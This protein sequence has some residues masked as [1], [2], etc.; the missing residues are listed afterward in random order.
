ME[1]NSG[2]SQYYF[3]TIGSQDELE[4]EP[5][6]LTKQSSSSKLRY[7]KNNSNLFYKS[8]ANN[9][10]NGNSAHYYE[11]ENIR[12][13]EPET[14]EQPEYHYAEEE[15]QEFI[16][17]L[18]SSEDSDKENDYDEY[19]SEKVKTS[20]TSSSKT[21]EDE[22]EVKR[23]ERSSSNRRSI[24]SMNAYSLS[25]TNSL[26]KRRS[27]IDNMNRVESSE[28]DEDESAKI[29]VIK[30]YEKSVDFVRNASSLKVMNLHGTKNS[31]PD[32]ENTED[33]EEDDDEADDVLLNPHYIKD[34]LCLN[35]NRRESQSG[36]IHLNSDLTLKSNNSTSP[37]YFTNR[38]MPNIVIN[39]SIHSAD[40]VHRRDDEILTQGLF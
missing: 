20:T 10:N 11:P 34:S 37:M 28:D 16:T 29:R 35:S 6:S 24:T 3:N 15:L 9:N 21:E 38:H 13:S 23:F 39:N 17:H 32:E 27:A 30:E 4:N 2:V 33:E 14:L 36:P 22:I 19:D 31:K 40:F 26:K 12:A 25:K 5:E 18:C 7:S 1:S 8:P